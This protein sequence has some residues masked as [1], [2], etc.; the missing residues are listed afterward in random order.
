MWQ[1]LLANPTENSPC[2]R[3]PASSGAGAWGGA[4]EIKLCRKSPHNQLHRGSTQG[5]LLEKKPEK[6]HSLT[7]G[8]LQLGQRRCRAPNTVRHADAS[9]LTALSKNPSTEQ[10][11]RKEL[12]ARHS[13]PVRSLWQELLAIRRENSPC[14][15]GTSFR[16]SGGRKPSGP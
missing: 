15:R 13:L 7:Q 11:H 8:K 9:A 16:A 5:T 12:T 2:S 6:A 10:I 14:S 4:L 1:Q 3:G